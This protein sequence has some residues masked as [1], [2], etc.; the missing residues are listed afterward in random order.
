M[1]RDCPLR[2]SKPAKIRAPPTVHIQAPEA[3]CEAR[4][5][6]HPAQKLWGL[7]LSPIPS[8]GEGHLAK[9]ASWDRRLLGL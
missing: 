2:G 9:W 6:L 7:R 3:P 5:L 1:G 4:R 8:H